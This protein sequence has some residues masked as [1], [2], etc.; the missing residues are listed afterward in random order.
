MPTVYVNASVAWGILKRGKY[1]V[2]IKFSDAKL[3]RTMSNTC[4]RKAYRSTRNDV[5]LFV[6]EVLIPH[7]NVTSGPLQYNYHLHQMKLHFG[8]D[9]TSGSEHTIN[10]LSFPAELQII[11]FNANLYLN[12]SHAL[13]SPNGLAA[14]S[15]FLE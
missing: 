8:H 15:I 10:G 13:S 4:V 5:T 14:F 9:E 7:L 12:Y 3:R 1:K 2:L 6:E 11:A